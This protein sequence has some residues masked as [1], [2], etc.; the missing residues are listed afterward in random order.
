[1]HNGR[2]QVSPAN[3]SSASS[4]LFSGVTSTTVDSPFTRTTSDG[5]SHCETTDTGYSW[6][7]KISEVAW[8]ANNTRRPRRRLRK[9]QAREHRYAQMEWFV[10]AWEGYRGKRE[11]EENSTGAI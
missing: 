5:M 4:I 1:M 2:Y 9:A 11:R 10:V 8:R 7:A 6:S 3:A